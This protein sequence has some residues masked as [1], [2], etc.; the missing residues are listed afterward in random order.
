MSFSTKQKKKQRK[1]KIKK[2]FIE[3]KFKKNDIIVHNLFGNTW[4]G[5]VLKYL[6][7]GRGVLRV[8]WLKDGSVDTVEENDCSLYE[9]PKPNEI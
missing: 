9:K 5:K 4:K 2:E 8:F 3:T 1:T 6:L 7:K